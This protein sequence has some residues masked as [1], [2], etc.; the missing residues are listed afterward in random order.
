MLRAPQLLI[1]FR[2][3]CAPAIFVLACF[4]FPPAILIAVLAAALVS[5]V[6]D[7]MIAR[8]TGGASPQLRAADTI[9]DTIF[10]AAAGIALKVAVPGA[11]DGLWLPL[12]GI[13]V[14]HV[15]R[16]TFELTKYGRLA[17][18]HMWSSKAL[19]LLIVAALTISFATERSTPLLAVAL[20]LGIVNELEGFAASALLPSWHADVPT[21][22]HA[23]RIS[24]DG[25]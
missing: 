16:S 4:E 21:L 9:V 17:A 14:V 7:G 23:V 2:A 22:V 10:Y 3:A 13:I 24:L 8:R 11:Y 19:G 6:L 25:K 20:W 5:D 15:S 12:V 18:Y 1:A